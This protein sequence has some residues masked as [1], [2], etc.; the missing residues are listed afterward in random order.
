MQ[1]YSTEASQRLEIQALSLS[2]LCSLRK[3]NQLFIIELFSLS[4]LPKAFQYIIRISQISKIH[5][6]VI[7]SIAKTTSVHAKYPE[8]RPISL[9]T[10]L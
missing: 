6:T 4:S 7:T 5:I 3:I 2:K 1:T 10:L 8:Y 9:L